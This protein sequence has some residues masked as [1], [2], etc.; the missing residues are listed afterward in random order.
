MPLDY[1]NDYW[2]PDNPDAKWPGLAADRQ[3]NAG[4]Q[5]TAMVEDGDFTAI[6]TVRFGYTLPSA[7]AQKILLT[8]LRVYLN[9]QNAFYFTSYSGFNPE[10]N[11]QGSENISRTRN[12]GL[13]AGNYPIS[14]TVTPLR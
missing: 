2:T 4:W 6:R 1:F 12:Y 13:D 5:N 7:F 9:V 14:R 10:G 8:K 11:N 3:R